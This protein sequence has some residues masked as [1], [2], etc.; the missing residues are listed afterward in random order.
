MSFSPFAKF[1]VMKILKFGGSSIRDANS[2]QQVGAILV[3]YSVAR[4]QY[5]V[6]VSAMKGV[7]NLLIE[8]GKMAAINN[9]KYLNICSDISR[10]HRKAAKKLIGGRLH[11]QLIIQFK[12]LSAEIDNLLHGVFLLKELSPRSLDLLQSFGERLSAN[13]ITAYLNQEGVP[14]EY[15]DARNVVITDDNFGLAKVNFSKTNR[16]VSLHFKERSKTQVITG[17]I[18]S[19][20]N[21]ETTTLGRGGSDY[22]AAIFGAALKANEIE[23][24]TDVN[25]VLTSDPR[26][27]RDVLSLPA[28]SYLEAM[29]LSHF[30]AKVIY[31]PTLQPAFSKK[32]PLRIRNTFN[33]E[34]E[35]TLISTKGQAGQSPIKGISSIAEVALIN[36]TGSGMVGVPGISSRLFG[37]LA[38][39]NIN[40]ILITQA[41]SEHSICFAVMP[42]DAEAAKTIIE[43]E[44]EAEIQYKKMDRVQVERKLSIV[45]IIGENMRNTPGIAGRLFKALGRNGINVNAIAQ[46]SSELNVSVVIHQDDLSKA[47]NALHETFFLSD[48]RTLNVFMVGVGLIGSTLLS[49]IRHQTNFLLHDRNLKIKI[50]GL[51]NTSKTLLKAEGIN[52]KTW[53]KSLNSSKQ[54]TDLSQFAKGMKALNL[55]YSIFVDCTSSSEV[56]KFYNTILT[57]SISIVTPNKLANSSSYANYEDLQQEALAHGVQFL[58][59]TNVGAGLPVIG[60]LKDLRYSGDRI[61]KIEGVLSGTLSYIFNSYS[62]DADFSEVVQQAKDQ[63][64]TEPDPRD[65]LNGM[66]V[67]RK[68][69]ILAREAGLNL[70]PGDVQVENILPAPCLRAKSVQEFFVALKKANPEFKRRHQRAQKDGKVLRFIATLEEGKARVGLQAVDSHHPFYGLSGSDNILAFTTERYKTTPLVIKGPGAGAEVTAAGVFAEIISIGNFLLQDTK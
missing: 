35:G 30:G 5:A 12:S 14:A 54:K 21:G 24:W 10:N 26:Q 65:D 57:S 32:I 49:Q 62:G 9:N 15:L 44:F 59:E 63:G 11:N 25:G 34:F 70:E 43:G 1:G 48:I 45:A 7:T 68:I 2:I 58:Y 66:D 41:S 60:T 40:I 42:D 27:V 47:L 50:I 37:T 18:G 6:V 51:A 31:P 33:P 22:T 36:V 17:F 55:P 39:H 29:E 56:I 3:N 8:A 16:K 67:A 53:K 69:L 61:L 28:I 46:G 38:L 52:L 4:V 20:L 23:I 64:F 13:L 19:S